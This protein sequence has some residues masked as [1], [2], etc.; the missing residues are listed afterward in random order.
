MKLTTAV[1]EVANPVGTLSRKFP[2]FGVGWHLYRAFT[3]CLR[4]IEGAG[5]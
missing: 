4:L 5:R 1:N 3:A 2:A